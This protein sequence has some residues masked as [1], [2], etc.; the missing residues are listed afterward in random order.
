MHLA[1]EGNR[2]C[3]GHPAARLVDPRRMWAAPISV[4][5]ARAGAIPTDGIPQLNR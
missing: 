4:A 1:L 5:L 2:R 3:P